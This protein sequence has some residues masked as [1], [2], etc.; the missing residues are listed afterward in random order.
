MNF[1][2]YKDI[3]ILRDLLLKDVL[4]GDIKNEKSLIK[5]AS[6]INPTINS[7]N[8]EIYKNLK[9]NNNI[10]LK[11]EQIINYLIFVD[12]NNLNYDKISKYINENN[13]NN[14]SELF[15]KNENIIN[16]LLKILPILTLYY[17][18]DEDIYKLY[19][20]IE[21]NEIVKLTPLQIYKLLVYANMRDLNYKPIIKYININNFKYLLKLLHNNENI[22]NNLLILLPNEYSE[23]YSS[24]YNDLDVN[25][26][27]YKLLINGESLTL[28]EIY[29]L[30]IFIRNKNLNY[31]LIS[32][33]INSENINYFF[34]L[35]DTYEDIRNNII[36]LLPYQISELYKTISNNNYNN[37]QKLKNN[38]LEKLKPL[39]IYYLLIYIYNNNLDYNLISNYING[40]N[41]NYLFKLFDDNEIIRN[42]I[43]N[44]L[45]YDYVMEYPK[46]NEN[47]II[48]N[49]EIFRNAKFLDKYII[50][51]YG[52]VYYLIN[53]NIY[54]KND[55]IITGDIFIA[56]ED[57]LKDKHNSKS[58]K[59]FDYIY[60]RLDKI[61]DKAIINGILLIAIQDNDIEMVKHLIH[62]GIDM[63]YLNMAVLNVI[64]NNNLEILKI[65]V[66]SGVNLNV[67]KDM[68]M[69]G[70]IIKYNVFIGLSIVEKHN[71]IL[72]YLLE[73][74]LLSENTLN[75]SVYPL[76]LMS[77][78]NNPDVFD[79]L[80]PYAN[81]EYLNVVNDK[82][83][84]YSIDKIL[85]A[86]KHWIEII[87]DKI[88]SSMED[89][90][91]SNKS[92]KSDKI[93][94]IEKSHHEQK[95]KPKIYINNDFEIILDGNRY[96]FENIMNYIILNNDI[97][98]LKL[99]VE[100]NLDLN[101]I[102][103]IN[104]DGKN[105]KINKYI[106]LALDNDAN[107]ILNY[108]LKQ[109]QK[110]V[111]NDTVELTLIMSI[112]KG[113]IKVVKKL[114][115]YVYIDPKMLQRL[116]KYAIAGK[117]YDIIDYFIK[118]GASIK[119]SSKMLIYFSE[120]GD[121]DIFK[122]LIEKEPN[123]VNEEQFMFY[124][125]MSKKYDIVEYL[126][127]MKEY[128]LNFNN[129]IYLIINH[130]V[131]NENINLLNY[132]INYCKNNN[133]N[134]EEILNNDVYIFLNS[135]IIKGNL[136]IIKILIENGLK[137]YRNSLNITIYNNKFKIAEYLIDNGAKLNNNNNNKLYSE[138]RDLL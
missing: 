69:Y 79:L 128:Y 134:I 87:N 27:L 1:E 9:N 59:V 40:S 86:F 52:D 90:K 115:K 132:I 60:D 13:I 73:Q 107:D 78:N 43:L 71:E 31:D 124:A 102:E 48:N 68:E 34:N 17:Y 10:N 98:N 28:E 21:N 37:Y 36:K 91:K 106:R 7:E 116:F 77:V 105:Y 137:E 131:N 108:L 19:D 117:K 88:R 75:N 11:I 95:N 6:K 51:K 2:L 74:N 53:G 80:L 62:K 104:Y 100:K 20:K 101:N 83:L 46:F 109:K 64:S 50:K 97:D 47:W 99:L 67:Y 138:Y 103:T 111:D 61:K 110:L 18:N 49:F 29:S 89:N 93:K 38:N 127:S 41:I 32:N 30:L 44:L 3:P 122:Y 58:L 14:L 130:A 114:F 26:N 56:Y 81:D 5:I 22:R 118:K 54:N 135:A 63:K 119:D 133:I 129:Q 84:K 55:T 16:N 126:L 42:N 72:K 125:L 8:L 85:L 15:N 33:Y 92:K 96:T 23:L 12:S 45:K 66:N 121:L 65:L 94:K 57:Y 70:K 25:V 76:L 136:E 123:I 35:F 39:E 82:N 113:N 24:L 4:I 120:N 112:L